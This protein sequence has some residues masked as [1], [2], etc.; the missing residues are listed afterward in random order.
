[1]HVIVKKKRCRY[2]TFWLNMAQRIL[3]IGGNIWYEGGLRNLSKQLFPAPKFFPSW[4]L[5]A[6]SLG[7]KHSPLLDPG[8]QDGAAP[9]IPLWPLQN[10]CAAGIWSVMGRHLMTW[11]PPSCYTEQSTAKFSPAPTS[12]FGSVPRT[13]VVGSLRHHTR[14]GRAYPSLWW[15][16][17]EGLDARGTAP[18]YRYVSTT[19]L[20]GLPV[21]VSRT[22]TPAL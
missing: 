6:G 2:G 16:G 18:L 13:P 20:A 12:L 19:C 7:A 22:Y 8:P 9:P 10:K 5:P 14:Q 4:Y 17:V 11:N 1:M 3:K 15:V 21:T